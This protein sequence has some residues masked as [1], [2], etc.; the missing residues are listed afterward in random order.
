MQSVYLAGGMLREWR[1]RVTSECKGLQFITPVDKEE[2]RHMA[3]AEYVAWDLHYIKQAD[4]VFCYME[5]SN[6]SGI[7]LACELGFAR[8]IG[9]TVV[10]VLEKGN[11]HFSDRKLSFMAA[12]ADVA[13]DS[14]TEGIDYLRTY[15][16]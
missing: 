5:R 11:E 15:C 14:L 7:G 2:M 4:I 12:M 9:K 8:G 13:F 6:S 10:L 1:E 16:F 3:T